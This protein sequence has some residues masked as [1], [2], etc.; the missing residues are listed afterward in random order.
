MKLTTIH[1]NDAFKLLEDGQPHKLQLWKISTGDILTYHNAICLNKFTRG[2]THKVR[3][4]RS[5]VIR[6]FRDVTLFKID[7]LEIYW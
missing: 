5:E 1:K 6:E 2:G 4:P 7:N 3:I